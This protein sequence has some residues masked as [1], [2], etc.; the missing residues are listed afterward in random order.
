[1]KKAQTVII[2]AVLQQTVDVYLDAVDLDKIIDYGR[3]NHVLSLLGNQNRINESSHMLTIIRIESFLN[4]KRNKEQKQQL[5]ELRE[6]FNGT[7]KF[8][9]IKGFDFSERL[10][11]C[12]KERVCGDIDIMV[13]IDDMF[14]IFTILKSRGYLCLGKN[15]ELYDE[16]ITKVKFLETIKYNTDRYHD[17]LTFVNKYD[18]TK[19]AI[20]VHMNDYFPGVKVSD[21]YSESKS[22]YEDMDIPFISD[23]D[24][25]IITAWHF[26]HHF[27]E[28]V[29]NEAY[30]IE[31]DSHLKGMADFYRAILLCEKKAFSIK[32]ILIRCDETHSL[33]TLVF[34]LKRLVELFWIIKCDPKPYINELLS[35]CCE[36]YGI[37]DKQNHRQ[38]EEEW[39][40]GSY[41]LSCW[42]WILNT[43]HHMA[44]INKQIKVFRLENQDRCVYKAQ[45]DKEKK[46]TICMDACEKN[47]LD[48]FIYMRYGVATPPTI[49]WSMNYD[50]EKLRIEMEAFSEHE[51]NLEFLF[52]DCKDK[53]LKDCW[54]INLKLA[55]NRLVFF[56]ESFIGKSIKIGEWYLER[57]EEHKYKIHGDIYFS[58]MPFSFKNR[59]FIFRIRFGYLSLRHEKIVLAWPFG[60]A[61]FGEVICN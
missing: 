20:E 25:L 10:Y 57:I 56:D 60:I 31:R 34:A 61:K 49:Q 28:Q 58:E 21:I 35:Q 11:G 5:I 39:Q 29:P 7:I 50:E 30:T 26:Y 53:E 44:E 41:R 16:N 37:N 46:H 36:A 15:G 32:Q 52:S 42:D 8:V 33:H 43:H 38:I 18:Q 27:N 54:T 17:P 4:M 23:V 13:D 12:L 19:A 55:N 45:Y 51:F 24:N 59:K 40:Y 48:S 1:M 14:D 9:P 22:I 3:K 6:A 2:G 47:R